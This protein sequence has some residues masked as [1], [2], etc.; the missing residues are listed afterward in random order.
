[1]GKSVV[2]GPVEV[3]PT[4]SLPAASSIEWGSSSV[5]VV[6]ASGAFLACSH[7]THTNSRLTDDGLATGLN[8][9]FDLGPDGRVQCRMRQV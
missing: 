6:V 8:D 7:T 9:M 1:M 2:I 5:G 4:S 3:G